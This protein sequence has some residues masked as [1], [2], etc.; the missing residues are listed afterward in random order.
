MALN[1]AMLESNGRPVPLPT[2]QFLNVF[3]NVD[4]SSALAD[5]SNSATTLR[6][7]GNLYVSLQRV[8]L[9]PNTVGFSDSYASCAAIPR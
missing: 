2:E 7:T 9:C 5:I 4:V 1:W 6:A 3:H 8:R